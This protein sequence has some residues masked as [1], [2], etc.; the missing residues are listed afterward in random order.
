MA[1]GR[2][3]L[4]VRPGTSV[5]AKEAAIAHWYRVQVRAAVPALID[6]WSRTLGVRP[7]RVF[8]RQ[9]KTMWGSCNQDTGTIRLNTEL[10]KKPSECLE[11]VVVHELIHLLER[12]HNDHFTTLMDEH[13]PQWPTIRQRLN[14]LPVRHTDW[15]Y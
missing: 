15:R 5:G 1:H 12:T 10:A 7:E 13:M 8:V 4:T 14:R 3:V 9:M 6:R 2:I 11:Y